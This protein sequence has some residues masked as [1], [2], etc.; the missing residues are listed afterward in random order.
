MR[1]ELTELEP[2]NTTYRRD[3]SV[4][5]ERLADL[6]RAAGRSGEANA[7]VETAVQLRY[8]LHRAEV[9]REDLAVELAY[10]LYLAITTTVLGGSPHERSAIVDLLV[11]FEARS[12][13][14][15]RGTL[16]LQWAR[17]PKAEG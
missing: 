2:G 12:V 13:L 17:Q 15:P 4:S 5:Y 1:E 6:A 9:E 16:I 10:A 14:G 3:V 8:N 11:P 7:L